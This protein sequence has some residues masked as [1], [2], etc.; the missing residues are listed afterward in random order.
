MAPLPGLGVDVLARA[1]PNLGWLSVTSARLFAPMTAGASFQALTCLHLHDCR[2][3]GEHLR[4][5][6]VAPRLRVLRASGCDAQCARFVMGHTA[7][8]E[9]EYHGLKRGPQ[10]ADA[11][12]SAAC[13]VQALA[14]LSLHSG[15]CV[16]EGDDDVA[17]ITLA[18]DTFM[19][20]A[21]GHAMRLPL[22][23]RSLTLILD[24]ASFTWPPRMQ[25]VLG[26]LA[27]ALGDRL[28]KLSV[29]V[30]YQV[31]GDA[32]DALLC[33]PMF[34]RLESITLGTWAPFDAK[35]P[36][37]LANF[38]A[39]LTRFR[40]VRAGMPALREATFH[41]AFMDADAPHD[42][43]SEDPFDAL[44]RDFPDICIEEQYEV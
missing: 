4:L 32:S 16:P 21:F 25:P 35:E 40:S 42:D 8:Q 7:L 23:L 14:R 2:F 34:V 31:W 37:R 1:L 11:W 3:G 36:A 19:T 30:I 10:D 33:L 24:S 15:T 13:S 39:L 38:R 26:A 6:S 9:L 12:L 5:S 22:Q 27:G 17:P 44:C 20:G 28:T 29:F 41:V 43:P 18:P